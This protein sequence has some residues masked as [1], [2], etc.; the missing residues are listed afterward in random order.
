[1]LFLTLLD[2]FP[3]RYLGDQKFSYNQ[4]LTF[5]LRIGEEDS[6]P[7]VIDVIF[8][9]SG[10]KFSSAIFVQGNDKP[11]VESKTFR[12]RLN[13]RQESQWVPRLNSQAFIS[14]LANLTGLKIRATYNNEGIYEKTQWLSEMNALFHFLC[15]LNGD[16]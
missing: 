8:E 16:V 13:E 9:G 11:S 10:Q 4:F 5:D 2:D 6:R 15:C 7:S 1:M 12:F 3:A 14:I